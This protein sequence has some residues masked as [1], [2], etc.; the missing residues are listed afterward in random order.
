MA[1]TPSKAMAQ[2]LG[3]KKATAPKKASGSATTTR[4]CVSDAKGGERSVEV[5]RIENGFIVR[6]SCYGGKGGYKSTE[7]FTDKA[8]VLDVV[9]P[10][11]KK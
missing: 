3:G 1:K 10:K 4:V 8:P 9:I 11:A 7:R 6:E 2:A 5:R